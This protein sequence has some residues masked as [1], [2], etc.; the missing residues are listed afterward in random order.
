MILRKKGMAG[1]KIVEDNF[2][3]DGFNFLIK[4]N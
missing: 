3:F 2:D 1:F 4:V